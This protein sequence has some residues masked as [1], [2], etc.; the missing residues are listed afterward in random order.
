MPNVAEAATMLYNVSILDCQISMQASKGKKDKVVLAYSGGLDT[1]V[2]IRWLQEKYNLDVVAVSVNVGQPGDLDACMNRAKLIGASSAYAV[3]ARE[4]F[5]NDYVFPS[6][7][8]N[9]LY[10]GV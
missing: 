3:D 2:A 6:L 10:E 4:Q 5:I 9:A 8:A 7:K 1:S